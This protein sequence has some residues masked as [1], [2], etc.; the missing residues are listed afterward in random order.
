MF[1]TVISGGPVRPCSAG[2][3][4]RCA[5]DSIRSVFPG[6]DVCATSVGQRQALGDHGVDLA[7]AKLLEQRAEVFLEPFRVAG[8]SGAASP[9]TGPTAAGAP[10]WWPSILPTGDANAGGPTRYVGA[11]HAQASL[12]SQG[13]RR[14]M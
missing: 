8:L 12:D 2:P 1:D 10:G 6:Q 3:L 13:I 14:T 9:S 7:A 4:P 5:S 11:A